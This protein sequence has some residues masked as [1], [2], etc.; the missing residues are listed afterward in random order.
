MTVMDRP[1]RFPPP[2]SPPLSYSANGIPGAVPMNSR[3]VV[4]RMSHTYQPNGHTSISHGYLQQP[5]TRFPPGPYSS[6]N[7]VGHYSISDNTYS[8]HN[9]STPFQENAGAGRQDGPPFG[10]MNALYPVLNVR[11]QH[12]VPEIS[13]SIQ[14]GFFQVDRKWTCYRRNY[15]AVSSSFSFKNHGSEGPFYL[16]RN[17]HDEQIQQF[18]V[19]IS[20]KTAL[21]GNSE[22]ESRGLVQHT[23]KRDKA[24]E[25]V[26]GRHL[27]SPTPPQTMTANGVY[28]GAG[29]MYGAQH[30]MSAAVMGS[31]GGFDNHNANAIPTTYTFERIQ[32]QKATANNGKRRAQ[33]QYFLLVVELSANVAR[34]PGDENWVVIATKESEPMVVRGRSPGHYK[35]NGRRDSQ[36]SMGPDRGSG[37]DGEGSSGSLPPPSY[38]HSMDWNNM[39]SHRHGGHY[40]SSTYR[41]AMESD[42]S[43]V[44]MASS[45]TLAGT[46]TE[47]VY[48]FGDSRPT[49]ST[50]TISTAQSPLTPLSEGSVDEDMMFPFGRPV[51]GRKRSYDDDTDEDHLR[52]HLPGPFTDSTSSV[53]DYSATP[54]SKLLCASS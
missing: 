19:S 15:F 22:S 37:H 41:Q 1:P 42:F 13:A 44:S 32:F 31:F 20:A 8:G 21:T 48:K 53:A 23:P 11:N 4:D 18:S 2:L 30:H 45:S 40:G 5:T 6:R 54:Y 36:T 47:G 14:K 9:M 35:D 27:I 17:G 43:P 28:A 33:Q 51:M 38:S 25:T 52:F 49:K 29:H 34:T 16:H 24:T 39:G 10:D 7:S 26:P 46:P 3:L 50:C 12:L